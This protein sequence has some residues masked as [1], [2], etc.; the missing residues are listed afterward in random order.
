MSSWPKSR[1]NTILPSWTCL[2]TQPV[3]ATEMRHHVT[4]IKLVG[5]LCLL[6]VSPVVSLLQKDAELALL[7]LQPLDRCDCVIRRADHP[8]LVLDEPF[9]R[10]L[11]GRHDETA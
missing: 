9:E 7:L 10:V 3:V 1:S 4:G 6:T 11:A 8:V 2:G 5:A